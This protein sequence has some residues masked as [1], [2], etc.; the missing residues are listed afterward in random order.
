MKPVNEKLDEVFGIEPDHDLVSSSRKERGVPAP[1]DVTS[2]PN[3]REQDIDSD[4]ECAREQLHNLVI[5]GNDALEGILELSKEQASA[6]SYEV[7]ATLIKTI[8]D[9]TKD[10]I[11]LQDDMNKVKKEDTPS[12]VNNTMNV[13]LTTH[14][15]QQML[16]DNGKG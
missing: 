14:E 7:A 15:L 11:K 12:T 16:S 6:R 10:L 4:Y 13:S 2:N 9:T 5:R 3:E 8:G 1:V